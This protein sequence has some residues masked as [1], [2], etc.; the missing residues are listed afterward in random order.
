MSRWR[1]MASAS[2]PA[3]SLASPSTVAA[4]RKAAVV[5]EVSSSSEALDDSMEVAAVSE[6][7][8]IRCDPMPAIFEE[9]SEQALGTPPAE[10]FLHAHTG[11]GS[12]SEFD[13]W[14]HTQMAAWEAEQS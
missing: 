1:A 7:S 9:P 10:A 5:E 8:D 13:D 4:E 6:H 11:G 14:Y 3:S 12:P 2:A